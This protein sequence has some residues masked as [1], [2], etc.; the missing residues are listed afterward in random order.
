MPLLLDKSEQIKK[1]LNRKPKIRK[2]LK[3]KKKKLERTVVLENIRS[4]VENQ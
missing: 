4:V 3:S 1:S 2:H